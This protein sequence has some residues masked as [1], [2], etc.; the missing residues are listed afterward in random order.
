MINGSKYCILSEIVF[1][2]SEAKH[3]NKEN[4]FGNSVLLTE[5]LYLLYGNLRNLSVVSLCGRNR[6]VFIRIE[7]DASTLIFKYGFIIVL[8]ILINITLQCITVIQSQVIGGIGFCFQLFSAV[9]P[10]NVVQYNTKRGSIRNDMMNVKEQ[11]ISITGSVN[12]KPKKLLIKQHIGTNQRFPV[13]SIDNLC[14]TG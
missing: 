3:R 11:V 9:R 2:K 8:C 12:F 10:V 4:I 6:T 1:T 7:V 14:F 5:V 13:H